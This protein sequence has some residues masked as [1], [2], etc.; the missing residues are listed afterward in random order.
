MITLEIISLSEINKTAIEFLKK[1]TD[2]KKFAIYGEM[3][4]G[5][6][7]LIKYIC[8]NIGVNENE[9]NSPTFTIIN[10]YLSVNK[11]II[12]HIDFY[13]INKL[14][15]IINIG[16]EDYFYSENYCFIEW[17]EIA[18]DILPENFAKVKIVENQNKSRSINI[19]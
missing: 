8:K 17:P 16:I 18:E 10:E 1:N 13:R 6:T 7:T 2:R 11:E 19:F 5:K 4:V 15:E 9:V 12:Y 3:G 14:Q